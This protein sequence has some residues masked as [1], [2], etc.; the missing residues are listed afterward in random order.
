MIID[1]EECVAA[2]IVLIFVGLIKIRFTLRRESTKSAFVS[3]DRKRQKERKE[4]REKERQRRRVLLF[5]RFVSF[6]RFQVGGSRALRQSCAREEYEDFDGLCE[7]YGTISRALSSLLMYIQKLYRQ[8]KSRESEK[9]Y[10]IR[11]TLSCTH[12]QTK[13]GKVMSQSLS[14]NTIK[15][16]V[17]L[18]I[19]SV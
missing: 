15:L 19:L 13:I 16:S 11:R 4:K 1:L 2:S 5:I 9:I 14:C 3:G 17:H 10:E 6:F 18:S 8:W 12:G 7:V